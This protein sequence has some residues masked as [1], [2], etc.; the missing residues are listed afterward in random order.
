MYCGAFTTYMPYRKAY[1]TRIHAM[2]LN[3]YANTS[4]YM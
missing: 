2:S 1:C 3:L 4:L